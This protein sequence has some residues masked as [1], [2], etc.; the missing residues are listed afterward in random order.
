MNLLKKDLKRCF[1]AKDNPLMQAYHDNEW[2][3]PIHDDQKH[4][5]LLCLEGA[6]AGLSW[7]TILNKRD[8]YRKAFDNFVPSV[9]ANYSEK[10]I[11]SLMENEGIVRNQRKIRSVVQNAKSFLNIQK[12]FASF[13]A[14]I[15]AFV[16][17]KPII[18]DFIEKEQV[19]ASTSISESIS[20]DLKKRGMNF[21]GPTIIYAYMQSAG[22]V[23]DHLKN[24]FC[25]DKLA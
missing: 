7:Q 16:D 10:K 13:D 8:S 11:L 18:N 24:C 6:Q 4:F 19:P 21:V 5:E 14:Y 20:K 2:G 9:V 3:V 23:W 1:W 22:L 25:N 12:E 17:H 15:W